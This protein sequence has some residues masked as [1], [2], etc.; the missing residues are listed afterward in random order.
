[1]SLTLGTAKAA[2]LRRTYS[3]SRQG[4]FL[5]WY[6]WFRSSPVARAA[7]REF[8]EFAHT[9]PIPPQ[10]RI[11]EGWKAGLLWPTGAC[12]GKTQERVSLPESTA[13]QPDPGHARLRRSVWSAN[14]LNPSAPCPPARTVGARFLDG[15]RQR[16]SIPRDPCPD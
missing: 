14:P 7:G 6:V 3:Y 1:M 9:K 13:A 10:K 12:C 5:N 15:S 2:R 11:L 4:R 8:D 16:P